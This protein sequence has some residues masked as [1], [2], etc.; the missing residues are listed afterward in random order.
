MSK[1]PK[2]MQRSI[3]IDIVIIITFNFFMFW[4]FHKV[5]FFEWFYVFS[6]KYES[7]ELDEIIPLSFTISIS[8]LAFITRRYNELKVLFIKVEQLSIRDQ[9]TGLYNRRYTEDIFYMEI[10]RIKRNDLPFSILL[11][12]IDDFKLVNDTYGHNTGDKVLAQFADIIRLIT[13]KVDTASR[14]GGEEFLILCPETNINEA[15]LTAKRLLTAI[16]TYS[17]ANVG[18][19]TASIGVVAGNTNE[20]FELNVNR[21]DKCLYQAKSN[22]KNCYVSLK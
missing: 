5:D 8:L 17:F 11:I 18:K 1:L 14:W 15:I 12:D 21:A 7:F 13:R 16:N 9:L 22:G 10:E 3:T 6:Q 20:S 2:T 19:V 4:F